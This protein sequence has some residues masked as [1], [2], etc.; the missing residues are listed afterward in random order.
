MLCPETDVHVLEFCIFLYLEIAHCCPT[1]FNCVFL[2]IK[3][4]K[5]DGIEGIGDGNGDVQEVGD[6]TLAQNEE[7]KNHE[8]ESKE[9]MT[10]FEGAPPPPH[11]RC[12]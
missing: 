2:Q 9:N 7:K 10:D 3:E 5:D 4:S 1:K 8:S 12:C 11:P 6:I